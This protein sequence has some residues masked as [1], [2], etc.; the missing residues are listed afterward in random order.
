MIL[1][2][3]ID[4][5]TG[6]LAVLPPVLVVSHDIPFQT[7][8]IWFTNSLQIISIYF[9]WTGK[10]KQNGWSPIAMSLAQLLYILS[11]MSAL[12]IHLL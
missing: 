2:N 12:S 4:E 1:Y 9:A 7:V 5:I 3:K 10:G 11:D 6:K 8:Y